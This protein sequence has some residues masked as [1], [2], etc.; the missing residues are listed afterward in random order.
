MLDRPGQDVVV[1]LLGLPLADRPAFF[2][3]LF[4]RLLELRARTGRPHWFVLDE[5]H[6]LLPRSLDDATLPLPKEPHGLLLLTVHADNISRRLAQAVGTVVV[7]GSTPRDTLDDFAESAGV[8]APA[9]AASAL[10]PGKAIVWMRD[11][12]DAPPIEL[13]TRP[14]QSEHQRHIRKY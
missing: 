13:T 7:I 14:P 5:A 6:H 2:V 9:V 8:D 11:R 4:A 12:P 3:T 10:A 1:N